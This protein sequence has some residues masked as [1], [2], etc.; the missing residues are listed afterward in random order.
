MLVLFSPFF[1]KKRV[2]VFKIFSL[3]RTVRNK[4]I[5][6]KRAFA[7]HMVTQNLGQCLPQVCVLGSIARA[8]WFLPLKERGLGAR[9]LFHSSILFVTNPVRLYSGKWDRYRHEIRVFIYY[10][11]QL[12]FP[13]FQTSQTFRGVGLGGEKEIS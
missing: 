10:S 12:R 7:S 8:P 13:A 2:K 5:V 6:A 3:F 11:I 4:V 9:C 1:L